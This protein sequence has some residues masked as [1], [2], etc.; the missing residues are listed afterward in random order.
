MSDHSPLISI[1][2]LFFENLQVE[3]NTS[4]GPERFQAL[5]SFSRTLTIADNFWEF[6]IISGGTTFLVNMWVGQET[7]F[8][9]CSVYIDSCQQKVLTTY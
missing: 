6:Q 9:F 7:V 5:G 1:L 2:I 3:R 8:I 4:D